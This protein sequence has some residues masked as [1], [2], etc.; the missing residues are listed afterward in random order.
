MINTYNHK[1]L[2]WIDAISPT[3]EEV[4]DLMQKYGIDPLIAEELLIP[5]MKPKVDFRK[6]YIY[7]I[8]H[9]PAI[10]HSH[11]K[12]VNQEID[13]I[14]GH[15]F[16]ITTRYDA[17][18]PIHKFSKIFEVNSILDRDNMG[19][20]A[21]F[22]FYYMIRKL[23]KSLTHELDFVADRLKIIEDRIF[24]GN[25]KLMVLE[26]SKVSRE[27]LQFKQSLNLHDEV[28]SSF[29]LAAIKFFGRD[30]DYHVKGILGSFSRVQSA[31]QSNTD[32]LNELRETN[33][34][35]LST[36]QNE[37]MKTLAVI[38][39]II[40]PISFLATVF[41]MN[42]NYIPIVGSANDFWIVMGIMTITALFVAVFFKYK[43]WF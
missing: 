19:D 34:S 29:E 35:L 5:S 43:N 23:Y 24:L 2:V 37:I 15:D 18:D 39:F 12:N 7:L 31:I 16:L 8:L 17:I 28:W 40:L 14:I 13:F 22:I 1:N 27:I 42:T 38:S 33:N 21:G 36:K 41:G 10:Y 9:F 32:T 25:E 26:L 3:K 4:R 20:S 11:T 6:N 30:F